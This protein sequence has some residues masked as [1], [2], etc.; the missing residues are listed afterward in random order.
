MAFNNV[1]IQDVLECYLK[2][3]A[4]PTK[5]YFIGL[6]T[7]ND[8]TQQVAQELLRGG[9]GNGVVGVLQ[10][11]KEISFT[12]TTLLHNDDIF[13]IQSGATFSA[14]QTVTV[15]KNE[16]VKCATGALTIEG[17][18]V[19]SAVVVFDKNGKVIEGTFA[20]GKVTIT[21]GTDGDWYTVV[22]P[23]SVTGDVLS[24]DSK[25]FPRNY[26]VELHTIAYDVDT[27]EVCADIFWQFNKCLPDGA[28]NAS[29]EAGKQV[30]DE[31]KFNA[32][33]IKGNSE[34][35][36]YVVVPRVVA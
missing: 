8:I 20:T 13:A 5:V 6:T 24:L 31:M 30:G 32:Q 3:L 11:N 22:Y 12:V 18:P 7:R 16:T 25:K 14:N 21:G 2:D 28:M 33:L 29:H 17:T 35:G 1:V 36:K 9:I 15:Q 4:D 27:N 26:Y 19:G 10:S 23:E 34:Y